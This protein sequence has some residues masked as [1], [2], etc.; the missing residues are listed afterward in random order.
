MNDAD[1]V[2]QTRG[3]SSASPL[4]LLQIVTG[5]RKDEEGLREQ[6]RAKPTSH[7]Y[8][9]YITIRSTG[10]CVPVRFIFVGWAYCEWL[11]RFPKT[12]IH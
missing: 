9:L 6:N 11:L 2:T 4:L 10:N 1:H 5:K 7:L 12:K 3:F 8:K